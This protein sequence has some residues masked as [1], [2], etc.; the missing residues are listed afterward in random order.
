VVVGEVFVCGVAEA[1]VWEDTEGEASE[2][3]VEFAECEAG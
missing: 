2:T 1:H 3:E